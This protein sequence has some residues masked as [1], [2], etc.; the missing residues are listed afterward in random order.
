M[1]DLA[2]VLVF[3]GFNSFDVDRIRMVCCVVAS[4]F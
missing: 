1:G 3:G 4:S 2:N